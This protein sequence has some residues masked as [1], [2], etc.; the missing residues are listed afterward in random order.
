M[1]RDYELLDFGQG[2]K[3]ERFGEIRLDRFS[4]PAENSRIQHP[5]L[6]KNATAKFLVRESSAVRNPDSPQRGLWVDSRGREIDLPPWTISLG[7]LSFELRCSPFGHLGIF[8]EQISNWNRIFQA[9]FKWKQAVKGD[10][11]RVLNLFAY[12]GGSTLAAAAAGAEVVHLDAAKNMISRAKRNA[13]LSGLEGAPIRWIAEDALRFVHREI[14]RESRYNAIILDPPSFGRG[15]RG[16]QWSF[17]KDLQELLQGCW[18]LLDKRAGFLLLSA[19][20]PQF[21]AGSFKE[22]LSDFLKKRENQD[23][24]ETAAPKYTIDSAPLFLSTVEGKKLSAGYGAFVH[25]P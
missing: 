8:A 17:A 9:I 20:S 10:R 18:N 14:R 7:P 4:P 1:E 16:E 2:R 11:F 6:W 24:M 15:P 3:L 12:T 19:H 23:P 5:E 22:M 21:D 13:Q 25:F